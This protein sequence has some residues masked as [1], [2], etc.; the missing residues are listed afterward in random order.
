[1]AARLVSDRRRLG[2]AI[3]LVAVLCAGAYAALP[4]LGQALSYLAPPLMLLLLLA[5]RRYP[6]ERALLALMATAPRGRRHAREV[7]ARPRGSVRALVP[8]GGALIACS[9]AV[10]PPPLAVPLTT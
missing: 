7:R 4:V 5:A 2:A 6:G 8:R 9:L 10:R 3:C 1:M